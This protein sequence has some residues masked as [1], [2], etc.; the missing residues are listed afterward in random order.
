MR[1][2]SEEWKQA[3]TTL[4]CSRNAVGL[5]KAPVA[6]RSEQKTH[7][8]GARRTHTHNTKHIT[9]THTHLLLQAL[10][11]PFL[12]LV[13]RRRQ[14]LRVFLV[15]GAF[16]GPRQR[17]APLVEGNRVR[18][19][20][21]PA[22]TTRHKHTAMSPHGRQCSLVSTSSGWLPQH[23]PPTPSAHGTAAGT[24]RHGDTAVRRRKRQR[25]QDV[26]P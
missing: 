19:P 2:H 11:V 15:K 23:R 18:V 25:Q 12:L 16:S 5:P 10:F 21:V 26:P 14:E 6:S 17:L 3:N 8:T 24:R 13:S 9:H 1:R 4:T 7:R 20:P 22:L